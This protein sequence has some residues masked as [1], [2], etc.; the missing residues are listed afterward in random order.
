MLDQRNT[1]SPPSSQ[2]GA[3]SP[4][5]ANSPSRDNIAVRAST[6][7]P[8]TEPSSG[9]KT[10]PPQRVRDVMELLEDGLDSSWI[11][12]WLQEPIEEDPG[13]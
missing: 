3:R 8:V 1:F 5:Q 6:S 2:A 12:G 10:P 4:C 9:L 13:L 7:P 11:L